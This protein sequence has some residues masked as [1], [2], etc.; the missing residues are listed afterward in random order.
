MISL[1]ISALVLAQV[2]VIWFYSS[3]A[4]VSQLNYVDM[5]Q[6]S[7]RTLDRLSREIRQAKV[8]TIFSPNRITLTDYD[9]QPLTYLFSESQLLRI[10]PNENGGKPSVMLKG[11]DSGS[12]AIYQRNPVEGKY[13]QY[14]TATPAT[15]KLVEVKWRCKRKLIPS[16]PETKESMHSAKI[17]IRCTM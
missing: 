17:V 6:V 14:P 4:F 3:R 1:A 16:A 5:D 7:Q 15:C 11:L 10:K 2:C 13:D 8:M 12:F 9:N